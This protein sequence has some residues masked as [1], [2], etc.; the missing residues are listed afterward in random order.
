MKTKKKKTFLAIALLFL[1]S[2]ALVYFFQ[3]THFGYLMTVPYER[4]T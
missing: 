1:L 4:K 2:A 3:F